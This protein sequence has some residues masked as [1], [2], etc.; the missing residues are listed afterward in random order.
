M[1]FSVLFSGHRHFQPYAMEKELLHD[2]VQWDIKAWSKAIDFWDKR[3]NWTTIH[4]CLE[5]GAREGGLS[6]WL[7]M[8]GKQVICSDLTNTKAAANLLHA[9]YNV[10]DKIE[11]EDI[12]ATG[13]PY[14]NYFDLIVFKSVLG[15]IGKNNDY[16][17]QEQA[18]NEI[19]KALKPGGKLLFAENLRASALHGFLR[20]F[21]QQWG[22]KW[23]YLSLAE[24]NSLLKKYAAL[25][26]ETTG[27]FSVFGRNETQRSLLAAADEQLLNRL[28]PQS[29]N[30][31][32]YGI[33]EK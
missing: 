17:K 8:K 10:A 30:Y 29:W 9:K 28:V 16:T 5:L 15:G 3:I 1:R 7:A 14:E 21:F 24:I 2:I 33:A 18:V 25:D 22:N 13:I 6:L 31:I 26:V 27:F 4:T 32:A 23:R 19:Y 20:A 12:D 11:Y